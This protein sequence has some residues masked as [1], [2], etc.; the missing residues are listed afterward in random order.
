MIRCTVVA[1]AMAF[2]L[3]S[4][5]T[6]KISH[7][8]K[9]ASFNGRLAN[10]LVIAVVERQL[11]RSFIENAF[12]EQLKAHGVSAVPSHKLIPSEKML[13]K[14]TIVAKM[15]EQGLDFVL[16]TRIASRKEIEKTYP[17]GAYVVP[18]DYYNGWYGFY[19]GSF[20]IV[21]VPGMAYDQE[22]FSLVTNVYEARTEKLIWS[23]FSKTMVEGAKEKV[24]E[25]FI[26]T[27]VKSLAESGLL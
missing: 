5:A 17:G 20:A 4:C 3:T 10:V 15:K 23:A 16:V 27:I 12:V 21:P 25:P 1:F 18:T 6:T 24:V 13:D 7:V 22:I 19:S 8:W 2:F 14:E 9:D 26:A 11:M